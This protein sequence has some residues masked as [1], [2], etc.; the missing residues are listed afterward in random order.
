MIFKSGPP[1]SFQLVILPVKIA[2]SCSRV[3]LAA[4][5]EG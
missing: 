3:R 5:L 2:S 4:E 1:T